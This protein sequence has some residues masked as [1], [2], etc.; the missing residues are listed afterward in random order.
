MVVQT[1]LHLSYDVAGE[2]VYDSLGRRRWPDEFKGRLVAQSFLPG[3]SVREIAERVG[4]RPNHLSYWRRLA[5]EG[6]LVLP[7]LEGAQFVRVAVEDAPPVPAVPERAVAEPVSETSS[8]VELVK[9][10][11]T[12]RLGGD[13]PAARIAEIVSLL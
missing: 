2:I 6:K 4:V 9:G 12:I 8:A 5:R 10:D 7:D 11:V 13:A 3:V 1:E